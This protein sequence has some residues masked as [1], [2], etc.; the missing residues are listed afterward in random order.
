MAR[1]DWEAV[2][3]LE[4][5][6]QLLTDSKIFCGCSTAF[7]APPNSQT[8]PVCLGLPGS[9][10]VLNERVVEFG[11][12]LG[13]ALNCTIREHSV[14]ARKNYFY[15]DLP[16]GYQISQHELP[17]CENGHLVI[18]TP[19]GEKKVGIIRAH[20]EE[21]AGKNLHDPEGGPSRVDLNRAGVP[22]MEIVSAPDIRSSDE[23]VEYLKNLRSILVYIGVNDGNLEE[24]SLRCDANVSV[25]KRGETG[26]R[27]RVEIKNLNSFRF[28]KQAIDF[29]IERQIRVWEEGG[30]VVQETRLFD[31]QA[32]LTRSMRSKE[33]AQDYRYFPEPDLPPLRVDEAL[34]ARVRESLPELPREKQA[35]FVREYQLSAY[36]ASV[37]VADKAVADYYEQAVAAYGKNPKTVANWVINEVLRLIKENPEGIRATRA[38]PERLAALLRLLDEGRINAGSAKAIL[39]EVHRTGEEPEAVMRA[40]GLEQVSDVGV[41]EEAVARVIAANP[42]ELEKYRAGKKAVFGFFMGQVMREL[43]GQG[44]PKLVSEALRRALDS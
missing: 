30:Q 7:G 41:I 31:A 14:F 11:V 40:R 25:R 36:D 34:V 19:E 2:I 24:G 4:V 32:G 1:S 39:E 5:H 21:D 8:C 35:R 15:P 33:E 12:R 23:A 6:A 42:A 9:L 37:L 13:L 17:L 43:K 27:T 29:E 18:D 3:G 26:F 22:L 44:D 10:P 28:L 16:K 38:E 20:L